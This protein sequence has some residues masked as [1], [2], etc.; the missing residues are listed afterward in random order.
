MT[1]VQRKWMKE[2]QKLSKGWPVGIPV[3]E[4]VAQ[5]L[6]AEGLARWAPPLWDYPQPV[7]TICL[8]TH[9]EVSLR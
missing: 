6:V 2:V 8:T 3:P 5:S 4:L 9:G 7:F 1:R